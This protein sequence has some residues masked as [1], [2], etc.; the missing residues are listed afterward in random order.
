MYLL[1]SLGIPSHYL[2]RGVSFQ[3]L[4]QQSEH[5]GGRYPRQIWGWPGLPCMLSTSS[6]CHKSFDGRCS[7]LFPPSGPVPPNI[8]LGWCL[9]VGDSPAV[10][11][12]LNQR[13]SA[14]THQNLH[15][16]EGPVPP[17][18]VSQTSQGSWFPKTFQGMC[19]P[20]FQGKDTWQGARKPALHERTWSS[21][22]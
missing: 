5:C 1:A 19:L 12:G 17:T 16:T 9:A 7:E 6:E 15:K 13:P 18:I 4:D 2:L 21:E 11:E 10:S 8:T 14:V 22:V 20:S 3:I